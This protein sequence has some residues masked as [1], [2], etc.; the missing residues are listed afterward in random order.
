MICPLYVTRILRIIKYWLKIINLDDH[1][2]V[3]ILY[4]TALELNEKDDTHTASFWI[5]NVK[6]TLYKYGFGYVWENQMYA[7]DSDFF[8]VFELRLMDTIHQ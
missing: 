4:H 8:D 1:S 7:N 6:N 3:K 5:D 2:P